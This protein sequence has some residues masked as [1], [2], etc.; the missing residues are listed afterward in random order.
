MRCQEGKNAM[1]SLWISLAL[2]APLL[3]S[4]C[5]LHR[6]KQDVW[7]MERAIELRGEV[8]GATKNRAVVVILGR[9]HWGKKTIWNY[10]VRYGPGPFRFDLTPGSAYLFAFEDENEDLQYQKGEPAAWYGGLGPQLITLRDGQT[11]D[12][13]VIEL[14]KAVP[15]GV[16]EYVRPEHPSEDAIR[17]GRFTYSVGEVTSIDDGRFT[18]EKGGDGLFHPVRN[19]ILNGMGGYFLEPYDPNKVPVLFVHGAGGYPQEF[20]ALLEH[21]DR[22]KFQPW[23][24]RYPSGARLDV[25]RDLMVNVLVELYAKHKY[26]KLIIIAHSMGGLVSRAAINRIIEE[27]PD[28]P[29]TM[30]ISLAT[31]W[32]GVET[33]RMGV[34][35]SP[36]VIPSWIDVVPDS[37]FLQ[38]L[39]AK[40]LP[41]RI[42]YYLLFGV[43]GGNG[44]DGAVPLKSV[45]SL[46]AQ[47][48]AERIFGYPENHTSIL[49]SDEVIRQVNLLLLKAL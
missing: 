42:P 46:R 37:P 49:R 21:M 45:V 28:N 31:P 33:A 41:E 34:E 29:L 8:V 36:L 48:D 30:F 15:E 24:L 44:T 35:H 13:L 39:F 19:A 26:R 1:N 12:G 7:R 6:V 43:T 40:T 25:S 11:A 17:L 47:A 20:K 2:C 3:I 16:D 18:Q 38:A 22:T 10:A 5:G 32:G 23:V 4:G 27:Y 9:D 14:Q